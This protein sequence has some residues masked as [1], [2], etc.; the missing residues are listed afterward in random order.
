[1]GRWSR[2]L[3]DDNDRLPEG[4]RRIGYDAD[5]EKYTFEDRDG[6]IWSGAA[7]ATYGELRLLHKAAPPKKSSHLKKHASISLPASPIDEKKRRKAP[8]GIHP[9]HRS[10]STRTKNEAAAPPYMPPSRRFTDFDQLLGS[11]KPKEEPESEGLLS[12]VKRSFSVRKT[13]PPKPRRGTV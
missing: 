4:M 13:G 8:A 2:Y 11:K 10:H 6:S 9:A 12:A 7:G 5:A 1:M 3:D